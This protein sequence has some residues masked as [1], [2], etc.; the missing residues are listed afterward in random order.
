VLTTPAVTAMCGLPLVPLGEISS[1]TA[2]VVLGAAYS[3]GSPHEGA[4]NAPYFLRTMS[5]TLAWGADTPSLYD[6]R[7]HEPAFRRLT[8]AGD[9]D[10][11]GMGLEEAMASTEA[12]VASLPT[13]TAPCVIGGDHTVTLAVVRALPRRRRRPFTVV[14]FDHHLDLQIWDGAPG[15]RDA[16]R[17]SIFHT[18]VMSHVSDLLGPGRVVQ[19]GVGPYATVEESVVDDVTRFL[20][21]VGRQVCVTSPTIDDEE[22][23]RAV[24]GE[25]GDVYLTVDIDVLDRTE[26][27]STG[28]PA[29]LGL[30]TVQLL[31]LI[32]WTA[33]HN[34]VVGF[35]VVEFAADR[36]DRDARTLADCQRALLVFLH[37]LGWVSR[38]APDGPGR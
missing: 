29:E 25:G 1:A 22:A 23:F 10:F 12:A 34:R 33:A 27:R 16:A 14:Q 38:Q 3:L 37:L 9:L 19:V 21:S 17:E 2:G 31:R 11:P 4:E 35:D 32:D 5:K 13:D 8:D 30:R 24:I 20:A 36:G 28:Y 7:H 6:L 26:M 15:D 18:N